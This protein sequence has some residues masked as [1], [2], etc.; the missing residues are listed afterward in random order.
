MFNS[1]ANSHEGRIGTLMPNVF[2]PFHSRFVGVLSLLLLLTLI[3]GPAFA[4]ATKV[5][6]V[7]VH[8]TVSSPMASFVTEQL[9]S[10]W[11]SGYAGVILDIDTKAG[12]DEAAQAIKS[13][14]LS[15]ASEMPIAAYIHDRALG[16]GS[17]IP[18][19]CKTVAMSPGASWG[20][21]PESTNKI[22][23]K[24][25]AEATGRNPAIAV[26]FISPEN[27]MPSLGLTASGSPLTLTTKQA[28]SVAFADVIAAGYPDVLAKMGLPT[29][30]VQPIQ[31]D[32]WT[33][34]ARWI[35]QPWATI[36][37]LALGIALIIIELTTMHSWGIAGIIGALMLALI[38]AAYIAVGGGSWVGIILFLGG[39][40]LL[41]VETHLFPGH[42]IWAI[43]GTIL[44]GV[45]MFYVLGGPGSN[46]L[47][48]MSVALIA[49][50]GMVVAFF[51]YLPRSRVW[52]KIGQ[53]MQQLATA[54]YVS[55]QDYTGYLGSVGT[56]LSY[57]RPSGNATFDG[58]KLQ[59]VSEGGFIA[60]NTK[61]QI[62]L[63][64]GNRIVVR[65]V[66]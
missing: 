58:D 38:F 54:G 13:A 31:F 42:G 37:L 8:G 66:E 32:T 10:A 36:L 45:G 40:G 64:Q 16:A 53:P 2:S 28:Q 26:A 49:T 61:V 48:S 35:A 56:T 17:L 5:A 23:F 30:S 60:E 46:A 19:A 29:A 63:V 25:A 65:A 1:H 15:H 22:E 3:G 34:I 9:D 6:L 18:L 43:M 55:S 50:V 41:L 12:T 4:Q 59:V 27:A 52:K 62:V 33:A 44:I 47:F 11:K 24:S 7:E 57:L 20:N 39:I 14:I 21:A 51:I